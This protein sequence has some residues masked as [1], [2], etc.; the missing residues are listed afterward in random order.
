MV[1]KQTDEKR[2]SRLSERHYVRVGELPQP[3]MEA[4][5]MPRR[6]PPKTEASTTPSLLP[7]EGNGS[8]DVRALEIPRQGPSGLRRG[9]RDAGAS[10]DVLTLD[11]RS[12]S[13]ID[14]AEIR[15]RTCVPGHENITEVHRL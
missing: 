4:L 9:S 8:L 11:E 10:E 1:Y 13:W 14:F 6:E 7:A 5:A 15:Q 3:V 2:L 12:E